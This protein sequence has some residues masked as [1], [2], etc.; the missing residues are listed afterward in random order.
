MKTF[1]ILGSKTAKTI[2]TTADEIVA[3]WIAENYK[4]EPCEIRV[5]EKA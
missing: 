2:A 3:K 5:T 1:W 4:D